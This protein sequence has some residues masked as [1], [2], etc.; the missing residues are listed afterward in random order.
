MVTEDGLSI[1]YVKVIREQEQAD[2]PE[3][4]NKIR[5][6]DMD[7]LTA[8]SF[9]N[10][11]DPYL[12]SYTVFDPL[13]DLEYMIGLVRDVNE[14]I[15]HEI[16]YCTSDLPFSMYAFEHL[17][18]MQQRDSLSSP[19]EYELQ[20]ALPSRFRIVDFAHYVAVTLKKEPMSAPLLNL[21]ALYWRIKGDAKN[22]IECLRRS[23]HYSTHDKRARAMVALGNLLHR[24]GHSSDAVI[25]YQLVMNEVKNA[26]LHMAMGDALTVIQNRTEAIVEYEQALA[27]DAS[28]ESASI[29][30]AALKCDL[31]LIDA[32]EK[33][34]RN[35]LSTISEKT[36]YNN[37]FELVKML[38]E[39]VRRN[40]LDTDGKLQSAL[41]YEFFTFGTL[42]YVTCRTVKQQDDRLGMHCGVSDLRR[43]R[44]M[45]SEKHL[46]MFDAARR[47]AMLINETSHWY[48]GDT[49][50]VQEEDDDKELTEFLTGLEPFKGMDWDEPTEERMYPR[51]I[52]SSM[53]KLLERYLSGEWPNKTLC[54]AN[55]WHYSM[56]SA[57][58]LP[59]LFMSPENKGFCVSDLLNKYLGLSPHKQ[60]PLPWALPR[61][62]SF[63][64]DEPLSS[65][66]KLPGVVHAASRRRSIRFAEERLRSTFVSLVGT[67]ATQAD[68]AQRIKTLLT[69]NIGPKWIALNLAALYWRV[70]GVPHEAIE[71]LRAALHFQPERHADVAL[72]QLAQ[73]VIRT[74][75]EREHLRDAVALLNT[76]IHVDPNEPLTHFLNGLIEILQGNNALAMAYIRAAVILDPLFQP[77]VDVLHTLKCASKDENKLSSGVRVEVRCCSRSEP[78]IFCIVASGECFKA[79]QHG[80]YEA[81]LCAS[82]NDNANI[83]KRASPAVAFIASALVPS[84]VQDVRELDEVEVHDHE[85]AADRFDELHIDTSDEIALDYGADQSLKKILAVLHWVQ[86][87][88]ELLQVLYAG[89][90][91][92][93]AQQ[94]D[95]EVWQEEVLVRIVPFPE[96][97][98]SLS[99]MSD[100]RQ[101]L[102]YDIELPEVLPLPLKEQIKLGL[103]YF[104]PAKTSDPNFCSNVKMSI[105]MLHEQTTSTWVSVTAKGVGLEQYMDLSNPAPEI[106][107][108]EP[109][110]P[111]LDKPSPLRTFDHLPAYHLREQ[112]IFYK[113]EKALTDAFQSLGNERERIEHVAG[114]LM[115]AMKVSKLTPNLSKDQDGGVHWTLSTASTLYWRVKGDAVNALK[116]LRHSLNNAPSDMKDVALV[117]MANI[118][119]QAGLLHSAL[120]AGGAALGI[121]PKL[122]AIHFTLA[123]IYATMFY[124]STLSLQS[125]FKPAKE[126]I[127]AIYCHTGNSSPFQ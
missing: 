52:E 123:N 49:G 105:S 81:V 25:L 19:Y 127:R 16:P 59:Q 121:S 100:R 5:S 101:M 4:E 14:D 76:A 104:P 43:Y 84:N 54:E 97:A 10:N 47:S 82:A 96:N 111:D 89:A 44:T 80:A 12:V 51:K 117:S 38:E 57:D 28:L 15:T 41:I 114:R 98:L 26:N 24:A 17:S 60:H 13:E 11:R 99:Q 93:I 74:A 35:L 103:Q 53:S 46:K 73:L 62:D 115:I 45:I 94:T 85:S 69:Y 66:F 42:P 67:R 110:C 122:V 70:V 33:Q 124:Y 31:K 1:Q 21:A 30:A 55:R 83:C 120:I 112:F 102:A 92:V 27:I 34:H 18:G 50:L 119:H 7:C 107:G 9:A 79:H 90:R 61:C 113:P 86:R 77:A 65:M 56:P 109:N 39:N 125:N 29:K 40:V 72:T 88:V 58:N 106:A 71:C 23:L 75:S 64:R 118:Y 91:R 95:E 116:C 3:I 87:A 108:F 63:I 78:N 6:S 48:D 37:R 8:G 68:V 32:M 126:R 36:N 20:K 22:A 2:D